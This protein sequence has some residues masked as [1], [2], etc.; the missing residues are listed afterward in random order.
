M[1]INPPFLYSEVYDTSFNSGIK[2]DIPREKINADEQ[3]RWYRFP[4]LFIF[5]LILSICMYFVITD[6]LICSDL[7][8]IPIFDYHRHCSQCMHDLCLTCCH[9]I[10]NAS[11]VNDQDEP[12]Y[13]RTSNDMLTP[14]SA[15]M[16]GL[17]L[18]HLFSKWKVNGDGSIPCGP[19]EAGGCG[20]TNLILRRILKINWT[21]KLL[22]NAEEMVNGCIGSDLHGPE[23]CVSYC[24]GSSNSRLKGSVPTDLLKC[25]YRGDSND[26]FLYYPA[27]EDI[28]LEGIN[29]FHKFWVDGQPVIVKNVLERSLASGWEPMDIWKGVQ[30][31]LDEEANENDVIVKAVDYLS[32][33]EVV[34]HKLLFIFNC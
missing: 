4:K 30:E 33:S 23:R 9:D 15:N 7:C 8:K 10:R 34:E 14:R 25:S 17:D 5:I 24:T 32:Q 21:G 11:L 13:D 19:D 12:T 1:Y 28:K 16:D 18:A 2:A 29:R 26:N 22:K 3:M 20:F 27:S 31:T 6:V